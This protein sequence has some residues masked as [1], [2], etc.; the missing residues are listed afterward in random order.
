MARNGEAAGIRG[1]GPMALAAPEPAAP[2]IVALDLRVE[3]PA[4]LAGETSYGNAKAAHRQREPGSQAHCWCC[5]DRCAHGGA[6]AH[7][8]LVPPY[9]IVRTVS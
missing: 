7:E 4:V 1:T 8:E 5:Q 2:G 3:R 9:E 6:F